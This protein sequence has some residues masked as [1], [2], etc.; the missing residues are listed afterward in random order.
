MRDPFVNPFP[1]A[2]GDRRAIWTMLVERD[3]AAFLA[4]DWGMVAGDFVEDEFLGI[5][6]RKS[7]NPDD[8]A[9]GFP[10]LKAYADE[11]LRQAQDFAE[12]EFAE[13]TRTAIFSATRLEEIEISGNRALVRKKFEGGIAKTDGG[14]DVMNWQTLYFCKKVGGSWKISGFCGYLPYPMGA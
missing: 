12:T 7:D 14:R 11:W 6:G 4:A 3:I 9:L 1:E 5:D 8:W 10:S 13:D 2:D